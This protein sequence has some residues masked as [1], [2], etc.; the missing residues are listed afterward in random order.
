VLKILVLAQDL[1]DV[2]I[3][4]R[5]AMLCAG[6]AQVTLAG[7]R[8]VPQPVENVA[9]C[10]TL[11]FGQ[12]SDA[13]FF[14]RIIAVAQK[15]ISLPR[16]KALF[17]DAEVI[18]ARNLDMLLIATCGRTLCK[19]LP[20]LVYEVLDIHPL[21]LNK[22]PV[23]LV[24]RWLERQLSRRVAAIVTSS[25][26]FVSHYFQSIARLRI[27]IR[28]VE[29]KV[30]H[31]NEEM[32]PCEVPAPRRPGPPWVIGWFG[33]LRCPRSLRLLIELAKQSEGTV[34]VVI[35]GKPLRHLFG[36][37]EKTVRDLPGI[38]FLGPYRNPQDLPNIYRGVHFSWAID[39]SEEGLNSSWLLP[40]RV[41][42]GGLYGAV[43]MALG[44]VETGRFLKHLGVGVLLT[45]S[46]AHSLRNFFATLTPQKYH[47]LETAI[48]SVPRATWLCSRSE[49]TALVKW[50]GSIGR[51]QA[52]FD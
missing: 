30:L 37:F 32:A 34:Q 35:R 22:G 13:R 11:D 1:A 38:K 6:G 43:P 51:P 10:R 18:I 36:D 5:I 20:V 29:N 28:L 21:M 42:E 17:T 49:S 33:K 9:G 48:L 4:R 40:N 26:A 23:G 3:Q 50:L 44:S 2:N 31:S 52:S 39:M 25:P 14:Q 19:P 47:D 15:L 24:L 16:Y 8:R 46:L 12:T 45:D 27:P 41:Y 7:F